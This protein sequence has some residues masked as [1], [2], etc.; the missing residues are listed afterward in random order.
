MTLNSFIRKRE[1]TWR[2]LQSILTRVETVG[3]KKLAESELDDLVKLYRQASSDLNY[4]QTHFRESRYTA[5]LNNLLGRCHTYIQVDGSPFLPRVKRFL[6]L[7]FPALLRQEKLL[8]LLSTA[9]FLAAF[10]FA[11]FAVSLD[12]PWAGVILDP[13]TRAAWEEN[14]SGMNEE[15]TVIPAALGPLF[16]GYI[17]TNNIQ[18]AFMAFAGGITCGLGTVYVLA[19]NGILL[20]ALAALFA[21]HERSLIFWALILPHGIMELTAIFISA[22][23]GLALGRALLLPG[24]YSRRDSLRLVSRSAARLLGGTIPLFFLAA[25]I[26]SFFTPSALPMAVKLGLAAFSAAALAL[27]FL[28]RRSGGRKISRQRRGK[29]PAYPAEG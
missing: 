26:E 3:L 12:T 5:Y 23:A 1:Q 18:V 19:K 27:Y 11:Y 25:V 2:R 16:T 21:L 7:G 28:P 4:L 13:E 22:A 6:L 24:D 29:L 10:C 15:G 8:F 17:A 9:L 14:A 20:G